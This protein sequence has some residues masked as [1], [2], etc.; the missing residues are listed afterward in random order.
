MYIKYTL[1]IKRKIKLKTFKQ[2]LSEIGKKKESDPCWNGYVQLGVMDKNGKKV[3]NC[4]PEEFELGDIL[5]LE[6]DSEWTVV[7][8]AEYQGKSVELNKPMA[9]DVKKSKVFVKNS[10]G[11]VIKV[12]FGDPNMTIKKHIP[13]NRKSFRA[14]HKCNTAKDFTTPRY[15][16]CKVW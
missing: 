7:G 5:I 8:E 3:P 13:A 14:R 1:V 12:N 16:S 4:I 10:Q 6:D 9:G 11:N 2:Y 15:W